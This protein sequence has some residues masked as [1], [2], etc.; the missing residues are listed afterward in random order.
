MEALSILP[1]HLDALQTM[2]SLRLSQQRNADA[3]SYM[4][5][6]YDSM[7]VG[8]QALATLV[9]LRNSS[10]DDDDDNNNGSTIDAAMELTSLEHVQSLPPI[11]FRCQT[12]KLLL[13]CAGT[14][15]YDNT[16]EMIDVDSQDDGAN[17]TNTTSSDPRDRMA[18]PQQQHYAS[19]AMDVIG[20]CLAEQDEIVELWTLLGDAMIFIEKELALQYWLRGL[21]LLRPIRKEL[22]EE[23]RNFVPESNDEDLDEEDQI[24]QQLDN[25]LVEIEN[26]QE[27]VEWAKRAGYDKVDMEEE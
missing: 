2:A 4:E 20:S 7:A 10:N 18:T 14:L 27:R 21:D 22:E 5:Q 11:E 25:I 13:E 16:S 3:I 1:H 15:P 9:G 12:I 19:A 8:C 23:Q 24:Q 26:L 6:V 17:T